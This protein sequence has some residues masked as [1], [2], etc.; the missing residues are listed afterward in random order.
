MVKVTEIEIGAHLQP[1]QDPR[2][3]RPDPRLRRGGQVH[4]HGGGRAGE[5]E[6]QQDN[7]VPRGGGQTGEMMTIPVCQYLQGDTSCWS[8]PPVDII[9][10]VPF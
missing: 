6:A 1:P 4:L 10:I 2:D 9:T 7:Q 3:H 5:E 8:K